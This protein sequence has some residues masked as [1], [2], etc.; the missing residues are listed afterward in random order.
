MKKQHF[1][2]SMVMAIV[3]PACGI[4]A[5]T[6]IEP[7]KTI[8]IGTNDVYQATESVDIKY[9]AP[10]QTERESLQAR[11]RALGYQAPW[12]DLDRVSISI[13]YTVTNLSDKPG[14]ATV[15]VDGAN[16]FTSYDSAA[17]AMAIQMA[18]MMMMQE[19]DELYIPSLVQ[20]V[21]LKVP[22]R[23]QVSGTIREDD[24]EEAL[25][26]LDALGRWSGPFQVVLYHDSDRSK[27]GLEKVPADLV[28]PQLQKLMV[29]LRGNQ[30]MRLEFLVRVRDERGVLAEGDDDVF[31]P[32]P[33]VFAP[34]AMMAA[35]P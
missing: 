20:T 2:F 32:N 23:G 8:E 33:M 25:L 3:G 13:D 35:M 22:A 14:V 10:T 1:G 5:P 9:R 31:R 19:E 34:P 11:S 26:D 15:L 21:P 28:L 18:S 17:V 12:I 6:Y 29:T 24:F 30:R 4:N 16:Q 7:E 27:L